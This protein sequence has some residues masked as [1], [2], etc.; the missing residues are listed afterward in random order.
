MLPEIDHD[1]PFRLLGKGLKR[2]MRGERWQQLEAG[3]AGSA[4]EDYWRALDATL[5][6]FREVGEDVAQR[7][8]FVYPVELHRR[9]CEFL[10]RYR[11]DGESALAGESQ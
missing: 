8:G 11:R 10:G 5:A 6:V 3:Y 4:I 7:L 2:Q 9:V 1:V